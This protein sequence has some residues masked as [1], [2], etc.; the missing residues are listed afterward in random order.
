MDFKTCDL[1]IMP[2]ISNYETIA[3]YGIA[4]FEVELYAIS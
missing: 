3:I 2:Q 1:K 4:N